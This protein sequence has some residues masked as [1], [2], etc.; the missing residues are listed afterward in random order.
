MFT[1][2][3]IALSVAI[4]LGTLSAPLMA[5]AFAGNVYDNPDW[6]G[7]FVEQPA[8]ESAAPISNR[9]TP[10]QAFVRRLGPLPC[11]SARGSGRGSPPAAW[12]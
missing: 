3:R 2:T 12:E 9:L 4:T 10:N 6:V 7:P 11:R 1:K 5:Y 8:R